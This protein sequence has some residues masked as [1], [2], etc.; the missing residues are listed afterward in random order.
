MARR[1]EGGDV[2]G[3][4]DGPPRRDQRSGRYQDFIEVFGIVRALDPEGIG[5]ARLGHG[6]QRKQPRQQDQ[7]E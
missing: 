7:G 5:R 1:S 4:P 6:N 2:G 3:A